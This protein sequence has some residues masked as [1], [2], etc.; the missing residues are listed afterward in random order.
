[1]SDGA[2]VGVK[3]VSSL[4]KKVKVG[5][6]NEEEDIRPRPPFPLNGKNEG[7]GPQEPKKCL[8]PKKDVSRKG[9][10]KELRS[11]EFK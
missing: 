3:T 4:E 10:R 7:S 6:Q 11:R 5:E 2:R 1:M 9:G 8:L